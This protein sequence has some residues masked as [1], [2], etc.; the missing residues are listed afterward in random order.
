MALRQWHPQLHV[1]AS[2]TLSANNRHSIDATLDYLNQQGYDNIELGL[3]RGAPADPRVTP[4][5]WD[6]YDKA[7]A[8]P[9]LA[10]PAPRFGLARLFQGLD[11]LMRHLLRHPQHAPGPCVAGQKLHVILA[12]GDVLPCEMLRQMKPELDTRFRHF[13]LGNLKQTP[14]QALHTGETAQAIRQYIASGACR[15]SFECARFATLAYRPW[16]LLG[17]WQKCRHGMPSPS[18]DQKEPS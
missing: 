9:A 14:P 6:D 12:N 1:H 17:L 2:L 8:H 4:A 11:R 18:A 5:T 13:V 7:R 10:R 15:C 3:L 16:K